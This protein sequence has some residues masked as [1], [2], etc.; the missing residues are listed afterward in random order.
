M[1]FNKKYA[2]ESEKTKPEHKDKKIIGD[3]A[4]A[5]GE[6]IQELINTF[7]RRF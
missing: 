1:D 2:P 3:E 4:Y 6:V 5:I 7:I